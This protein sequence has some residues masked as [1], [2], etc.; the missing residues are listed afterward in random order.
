[1]SN[2]LYQGQFFLSEKNLSL[3]ELTEGY[4]RWILKGGLL[5]PCKDNFYILKV[6]MCLFGELIR[7]LDRHSRHCSLKLLEFLHIFNC[8][9][10]WNHTPLLKIPCS[11]W[12]IVLIGNADKDVGWQRCPQNSQP[13]SITL[14]EPLFQ[15]SAFIILKYHRQ[16]KMI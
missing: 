2:L 10:T 4:H 16:Y 3:Q 12:W 1:M 6:V 15:W 13:F 11:C 8:S 9:S 7:F 5:L 14:L